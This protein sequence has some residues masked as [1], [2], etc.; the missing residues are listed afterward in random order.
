[1]K[2]QVQFW[3]EFNSNGRMGRAIVT[4]VERPAEVPDEDAVEEAKREFCASFG[5]PNW[6]HRAHGFRVV[7][8]AA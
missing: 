6:Q 8:T 4:V 1:M 7:R 5:V 3:R 2:T